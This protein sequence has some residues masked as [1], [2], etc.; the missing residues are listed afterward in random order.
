LAGFIDELK[1]M[2]KE[3]AR[4]AEQTNLIAL[5][6]AIEAARAGE[7]GRG[8]A[9]V[10]DEVRKLSNQ[11]G[12]TGKQIGAKVEQVSSAIHT[13]LTAVEKSTENEA[14][15]AA[16]SSDDIQT[17]LN[18]LQQVFGKLQQHSKNLGNSAHAI[19]HEIDESLVLFQFQDRIGQVLSHVSDSI[20][21]FPRYVNRSHA[22]GC[23]ALKPLATEEIVSSLSDTYTM[24][25]EHRA[26]GTDKH[27]GEQQSSEI[28][29]F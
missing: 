27:A 4:I 18:N 7:A 2:A 17:V 28:T 19:K 24:E 1:T 22:N 12:E 21:A 11:S 13:T 15:A 16:A 5:N 3:V 26:H 10:A 29:F 9:V 20:N 6:A 14:I 8:F 25:S 23:E